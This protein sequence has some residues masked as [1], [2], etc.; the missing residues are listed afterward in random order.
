MTWFESVRDYA[1]TILAWPHRQEMPYITIYQQH[2][3]CAVLAENKLH[4]M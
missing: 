4:F 3:P 1:V 2:L